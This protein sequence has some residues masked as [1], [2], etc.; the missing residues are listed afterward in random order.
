M[1]DGTRNIA[2]GDVIFVKLS[3]FNQQVWGRRDGKP[4]V[5]LPDKTFRVLEDDEWNPLPVAAAT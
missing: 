2:T 1:M 4:V 3:G 5:M